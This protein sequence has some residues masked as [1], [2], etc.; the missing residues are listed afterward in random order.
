M[1][2]PKT[3][4]GY[5]IP[6]QHQQKVN[7]SRLRLKK[8]L[9][10]TF[11]YLPERLFSVQTGALDIESVANNDTVVNNRWS[12]NTLAKHTAR[13]QGKIA[14]K[15]KRLEHVNVLTSIFHSSLNVIILS[16]L[17]LIL[18]LYGGNK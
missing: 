13:Q 3:E 12:A 6:T 16:R 17:L 14:L 4:N 9:V 11:L 1:Y 10:P 8:E 15:N 2:I 7:T 5:R 18:L